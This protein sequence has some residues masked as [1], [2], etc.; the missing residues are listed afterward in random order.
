MQPSQS[1]Q[2]AKFQEMKISRKSK[3]RL[4]FLFFRCFEAWFFQEEY[5]IHFE[6]HS[7]DFEPKSPLEGKPSRGH[8]LSRAVLKSLQQNTSQ[9]TPSFVNTLLFEGGCPQGPQCSANW[10][11]SAPKR[12]LELAWE[13]T[14]NQPNLLWCS[15]GT[16]QKP[17]RW[18]NYHTRS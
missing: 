13:R 2:A 4:I 12:T 8:M 5:Y 3:L 14:T 6:I 7:I 10:W 1:L 17:A 18:L 16:E 11:K 15:A 9:L